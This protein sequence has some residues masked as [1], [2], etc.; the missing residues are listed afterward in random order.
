M[1]DSLIP[2]IPD[3]LLFSLSA[4]FLFFVYY[5]LPEDVKDPIKKGLKSYG[6]Y[7]VLILF[8]LYFRNKWGFVSEH[9]WIG[10]M[11]Y[12]TFL[13]FLVGI[14]YFATKSW[15]YEQRYYTN[16]LI[17]DNISG[18]VHRYQ[19]IGSIGSRDNWVV[20]FLGTSGTSDERFVVPWPWAKKLIVVPKV[21]C[22]FI[23]N[24]IFVRSQVAKADI[25]EL[26][27]EVAHFIEHD[28]FGRWCK[29]EIYFGLWSIRAK[30]SDPKF[31]ELESTMKKTNSRINE[32]K[33]M[34]EGKLTSTKRFISDTLAMQDKLKGK[35]FFRRQ[36][37]GG[38][39]E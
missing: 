9:E 11:K 19:E 16:Q 7:I 13:I 3:W 6:I 31:E 18:S 30:A 36:E 37:Q 23:G 29:D 35:S 28:T 4:V 24:Q 25:L 2:Y 12:A 32:L 14:L 10:G 26:P 27:E 21:A 38:Y 34:L 5:Y 8:W 1:V 20:F 33:A 39:D 17:C 22:E 15:L